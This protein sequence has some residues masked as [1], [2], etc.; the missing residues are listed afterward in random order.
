MSSIVK[1]LHTCISTSVCLLID[2]FFLDFFY[3]CNILGGISIAKVSFNGF[4]LLQNFIGQSH[5]HIGLDNCCL[6]VNN[7]EP[8]MTLTLEVAIQLCTTK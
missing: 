2:G 4:L 8:A 1:L 6:M 7:E 5:F 3:Y